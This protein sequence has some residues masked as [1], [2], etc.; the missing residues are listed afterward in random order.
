MDGRVYHYKHLA[1]AVAEAL[2]LAVGIGASVIASTRPGIGA[3]V[4]TGTR[5]AHRCTHYCKHPVL[6]LVRVILQAPGPGVGVGDIASAQ[7]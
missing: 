5:P 1:L 4:I 6:V 3:G 7:P 2:L